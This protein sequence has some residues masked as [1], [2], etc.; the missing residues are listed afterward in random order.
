MSGVA[1][2]I[3]GDNAQAIAALNG[4]AN[5]AESVAE[6]IRN[7]FQQRIGQR[8][9][10]GL[11][12]AAAALPGAM[13]DA[14]DAGGRLSDQMA[15]TGAAGEGLVVLERALKNAGIESG[16]TVTLLGLM[17]KSIAGLNEENQSTGEAFASLGLNMANLRSMDPV[18]AF[19]AIGKAIAGVSDP[20][21]RTALAMRIFGRSGAEALVVFSEQ[22]ALGKA[23]KQLG[24]LPST[25]AASAAALDTVSDRMGNLNTGWQQLAASAAVAVLPA[26]TEITARIESMDL[27]SLGQKIGGVLNAFVA[28]APAIKTVGIVLVGLKLSSIITDLNAKRAAWW[29]ST[30]AINANT[31]A[32]RA[33]SA[34]GST[35]KA[36]GGSKAG[37]MAGGA[38]A[39]AGIGLQILD[40]ATQKLEA[41]NRAMAE[42]FARGQSA[43]EKFSVETIRGQVA[44]REEIE[45]TVE[46]IRAE[47]EA[48]NKAAQAQAMEAPDFETSGRIMDDAQT[49]IDLLETKIK[50]IRQTSNEQL[51]ANQATR[52]AAKAEQEYQDSLKK[53]AE[54]YEVAKK[55]FQTTLEA[56]E[57]KSIE[58]L[59]LE[60]Q[61]KELEAAEKKVRESF[62]SQ[63]QADYKGATASEIAAGLES[64][65]NTTVRG[66]EMERVNQL[67][68][69]E[70]RRAEIQEKLAASQ[71]ESAQK[72]A[73]AKTDYQ[74]ELDM[75]NAELDGNEEKLRQLQKEAEIRQTIA[76][77]TGSGM[78]ADTAAKRAQEMAEKR[79]T[80]PLAN[81]RRDARDTLESARAKLAGPEA[82]KE[83]TIKRRAKELQDQ[84]G[85][86]EKEARRMAKGES[87]FEELNSMQAPERGP[88]FQGVSSMAAIGGGG[89][90]GPAMDYQRQISEYNQRMVQLLETIAAAAEPNLAES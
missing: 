18:A 3:S 50:L 44:T 70:T 34:A 78:D 67:L 30:Q 39:I 22:D 9:F 24:G 13:K 26:L 23:R 84:T 29:G 79:A 49:S 77:L 8:M 75:L 60:D 68:D 63:I 35:N 56:N 37:L 19:E 12:R 61:L 38:L 52:D 45:K 48:L 17:Q 62:N 6:R 11:A 21:E 46:D 71:K 66:E 81:A 7:G 5:K 4:V 31:A 54:T 1:V 20:A 55:A 85:M 15:R 25:L 64:G 59:P 33:N 16:K 53:S 47:Q 88:A 90:V 2:T 27:T 87:A 82:E 80:I 86:D 73:E 57:K 36:S 83:L 10:D 40:N 65:G 43:A 51:S 72:L 58:S 28:L 89:R 14:I 69:I 74:A 76:Q 32:L 41:A 42:S